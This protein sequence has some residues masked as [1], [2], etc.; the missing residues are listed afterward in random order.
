VRSASSRT[1]PPPPARWPYDMTFLTGM[2]RTSL[3][4]A[5]SRRKQ[6]GCA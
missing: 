6:D 4:G 2:T 1:S 5:F 3:T